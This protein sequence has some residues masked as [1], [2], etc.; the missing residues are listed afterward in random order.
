MAHT[1]TNEPQYAPAAGTPVAATTTHTDATGL[2]IRRTTIPSGADQVPAY[3]AWPEAGP[4]RPVVLVLSEAFG[5]HEHIADITRRFARQGYFAIA[6]DLMFRQGDPM[7]FTDVMELVRELLLKIPDGQVLDDLDACVTWAA[8]QGGDVGHLAATGFCWGGRW[9]WLY[10]AHR[11][12]GAAVAWYGI[13]DGAVN[14]TFPKDS[15]RFPHHPIDLADALQ[16]PVLGLY[17]GKDDAIPLSSIQ[18]MQARLA[19]GDAAA[20]HSEIRVYPDAGHAFFADYRATYE[21]VAAA[22]AWQRCL[23]R[24]A[25]AAAA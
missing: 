23:Q 15:S 11:A 21:P 18:E 25:R 17:G 12:F 4:R 24:I 16:T 13:L 5:L 3:C 8:S 6:P 20:R 14:D 22:D 2:T 19:A 9:T 10:A 1:E 7:R